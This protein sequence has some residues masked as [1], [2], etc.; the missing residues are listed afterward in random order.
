MQGQPLTRTTAADGSWTYTLYNSREYPFIHALPLGQGGWAACIELPKA[1]R[2]R[3]GT[4]RLRARRGHTLQ[5]LGA[6]GRGRRHGRPRAL[7]AGAD[8]RRP[9]LEPALL[10]DR[11]VVRCP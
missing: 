9:V 5:V 1:W 3:A 11:R 4:L 10:R 2:D 7:E 8:P 6:T